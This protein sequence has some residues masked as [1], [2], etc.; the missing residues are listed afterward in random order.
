MTVSVLR[1]LFNISK[2]S[3]RGLIILGADGAK[4]KFVTMEITHARNCYFAANVRKKK[5]YIES[6]HLWKIIF[7]KRK[8]FCPRPRAKTSMYPE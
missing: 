4:C 1:I 8:L 5:N 2:Q 7:D 3:R 6:V